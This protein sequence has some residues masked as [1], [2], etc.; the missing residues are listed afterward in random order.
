MRKLKRAQLFF[1][2]LAI[3]AFTIA[4]DVTNKLITLVALTLGGL[5][6]VLLSDDDDPNKD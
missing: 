2:M 4:D 5:A 1:T 6:F 3:V